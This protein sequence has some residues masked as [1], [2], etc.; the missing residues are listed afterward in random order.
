MSVVLE[1]NFLI[2]ISETNITPFPRVR[3][4]GLPTSSWQVCIGLRAGSERYLEEVTS[5]H[6]WS[7]QK[8]HS[9]LRRCTW[10]YY[11]KSLFFSMKQILFMFDYA[12]RFLDLDIS[13][14][15]GSRLTW[16]CGCD[17]GSF[18]LT[19]TRSELTCSGTLYLTGTRSPWHRPTALTNQSL[20]SVTR[21]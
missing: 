19:R 5:G 8:V 2:I 4:H 12:T 9:Q 14:W 13:S 3:M 10:I 6:A 21:R 15:L 11:L 18:D 16:R 17:I 1:N 20:Y 7:G